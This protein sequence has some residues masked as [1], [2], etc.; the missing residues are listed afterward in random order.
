[1]FGNNNDGLRS[2]LG[3]ESYWNELGTLEEP[4]FYPESSYDPMPLDFTGASGGFPP[5]PSGFSSSSR[6]KS[7][8]HVSQ[9]SQSFDSSNTQRVLRLLSRNLF[10]HPVWP[11]CFSSLWSFRATVYCYRCDGG[12]FAKIDEDELFSRGRHCP[13]GEERGLCRQV[14]TLQTSF[15]SSNKWIFA[16]L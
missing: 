11:H 14:R 15:V 2:S 7:S 12:I 10:S 1:M 16:W 6:E 13:S 3:F 4:N 9:N 5:P 8:A